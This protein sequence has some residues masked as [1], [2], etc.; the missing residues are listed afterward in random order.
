MK[1]NAA[2]GIKPQRSYI[3]GP[4]SLNDMNK[5]GFNKKTVFAG[6]YVW[7]LQ[8]SSNY[9]PM[10]VGRDDNVC[11][12]LF[13]HYIRFCGGEYPIPEQKVLVDPNRDIKDLIKH[14]KSSSILPSGLNYFPYGSFDFHCFMANARIQSTLAFFRKKYFACW[15]CLPDYHAENAAIEEGNLAHAIGV[16]KLIGT[17]YKASNSN[18]DFIKDFLKIGFQ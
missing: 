13:Q 9:F 2:V 7:G 8:H 15:K 6:I 11:E 18:L 14:A 3:H 16:N 1:L 10:Y 17:R 4:Y 12:R 5:N